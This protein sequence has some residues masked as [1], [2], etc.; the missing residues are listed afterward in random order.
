M[1][2]SKPELQDRIITWL[3]KTGLP[4]ELKTA[5]AFAAEGFDAF[6]SVIYL[7]PETQKGREIDVVAVQGSG[8]AEPHVRYVVECK[9][10]PK[11]QS[12]PW[13]VIV[14]EKH[15]PGMFG[16]DYLG[17][18]SKPFTRVSRAVA[19]SIL[20]TP[21]VA[22]M[23]TGGYLLRQAF[24]GEQDIAYTTSLSVIN[25]AKA[26]L[27]NNPILHKSFAFVQPVI[28]VEGP[29]FECEMKDDDQFVLREVTVSA[30]TFTQANREVCSIRIASKEG[31]PLLARQ[32][33]ETANLL[34][35]QLSGVQVPS[36][37]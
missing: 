34:K 22:N 27:A 33:R 35:V 14:S 11:D 17:I 18:V 12:K 19:R 2:E 37:H 25:A 24:S 23:R 16:V 31:L 36:D 20:G 6:H 26:V 21:E 30:Y 9:A 8:G 1:S 29:L 28:V 13:I 7:D 5:S 32:C 3:H 10:S 15:K 4:L